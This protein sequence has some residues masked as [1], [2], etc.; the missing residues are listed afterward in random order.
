MVVVVLVIL[1]LVLLLRAA[2]GATVAEDLLALPAGR[3]DV[4][5]CAAVGRVAAEI[6]ADVAAID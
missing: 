3:A 1:L 5:A 2:A 4:A 6:G